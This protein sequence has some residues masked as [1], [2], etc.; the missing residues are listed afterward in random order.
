MKFTIYTTPC[1]Q[2]I[3]MVPLQKERYGSRRQVTSPGAGKELA[4][5]DA[6][7]STGIYCFE[8]VDGASEFRRDEG[9]AGPSD[10]VVT[11]QDWHRDYAPG[12]LTLK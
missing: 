6:A 7:A 9:R 5:G 12:A 4:A 2:G 3:T 8:N 10:H 11:V 1:Q